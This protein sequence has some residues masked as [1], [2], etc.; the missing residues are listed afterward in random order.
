MEAPDVRKESS[1][2]TKPVVS[3]VVERLSPGGIAKALVHFARQ[4]D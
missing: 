4:M 1:M 2:T 3:R